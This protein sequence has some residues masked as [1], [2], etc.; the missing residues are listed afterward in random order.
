MLWLLASVRRYFN[1][2]HAGVTGDRAARSHLCWTIGDR[3]WRVQAPM[4]G[5]VVAVNVQD[6]EA[7]EYDQ[8]LFEMRPAMA[9]SGSRIK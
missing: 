5:E 3:A 4:D 9:S 7:V 1:Q 6:E 2:G 8:V